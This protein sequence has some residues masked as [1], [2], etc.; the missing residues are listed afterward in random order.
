MRFVF[1]AIFLLFL[2]LLC[3]TAIHDAI[4][5]RVSTLR[6]LGSFI[7]CGVLSYLAFSSWRNFSMEIERLDRN[8]KLLLGRL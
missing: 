5:S 1:V 6:V 8:I 4:T 2:A 3:F 7:C